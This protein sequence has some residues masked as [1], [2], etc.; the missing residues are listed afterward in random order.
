[1]ATR[2]WTWLRV[3]RAEIE[4][5]VVIDHAHSEVPQPALP[6]EYVPRQAGIFGEIDASL[7]CQSPGLKNDIVTERLDRTSDARQHDRSSFLN[8][9][10]KSEA[11]LMSKETD[12]SACVHLRCDAQRLLTICQEHGDSDARWIIGIWKLF[13]ET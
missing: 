10:S 8:R 6:P 11:D 3:I 13:I 7:K 12:L 1:M 5:A 4:Q 9:E 2:W